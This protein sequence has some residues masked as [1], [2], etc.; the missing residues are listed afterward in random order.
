M[1]GTET[2]VQQKT[3]IDCGEPGEPN[4]TRWINLYKNREPESGTRFSSTVGMSLQIVA[5]LESTPAKKPALNL[6]GNR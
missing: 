1:Q 2:G 4:K 6:L 5:D 3:S